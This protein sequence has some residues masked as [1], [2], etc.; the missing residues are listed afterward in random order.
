MRTSD[1]IDH[2]VR[3]LAQREF[4]EIRQLA[5]RTFGL[6]LKPGKEQLVS[7]RLQKLL[8][9]GGFHS[10]RDYCRHISRDKTG[11]SLLAL[12]D[13]LATNHTAF[14]RE[15][16]HFDFLRERFFRFSPS[17]RRYRFGVR[18]VRR[19]KSFG[20]WPS[21]STKPSPEHKFS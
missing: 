16:A 18:A 19:E 15:P 14:L 6:D 2:V 7:A 8:R 17:V 13:A 21:C 12:I 5:Y 20:L 1:Q 11:E 4:E 10:Y 3:P 9:S